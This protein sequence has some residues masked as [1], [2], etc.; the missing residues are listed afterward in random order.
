ML[1]EAYVAK[2]L[3]VSDDDDD[4]GGEKRESNSIVN[5]RKVLEGYVSR[6]EDL[7]KYPTREF[8]DDGISGVS[9]NRPGVQSLLREVRENRVRCIIVKDLSRFGRNYIEV[10][11]YIEQIFP[12]L[13]VRFIAVSDHFDSFKNPV[14][15]EIGFKNLIHD[16]YSRDLSRKIKSVKSLMQ[17]RGAY[18]GGDVP[19]GYMRSGQKDVPYVPDPEAAQVVKRIFNLAAAGN[20]S[21]GIAD[22]LNRDAVPTPGV[23]KNRRTNENYRL[24]NEKSTLW[25]ASQVGV[26]IQNEVY[27]GTSILHKLSTVRPRVSKR[28][29]ESEYLKIENHHEKLVEEELFQKAQ[30]ALRKRKKRGGYR[31][32]EN[33]PALKGKV[34]CGCCGYGMS[35]KRTSKAPYYYCRMGNGCGSHIKIEAA[36]LDAAILDVLRKYAEACY[37]R[38]TARESE[39]VQMLTALSKGKE[40]KRL[41]EIRAEHCKSSRLALY[42]QWKEGKISKEEYVVK[43]EE[44]TKREAG[45]RNELE[46]LNQQLEGMLSVREDFSQESVLAGFANVQNLTKELADELIGRV[47]V[48]EADRVEIKWKV[49]MCME[50]FVGKC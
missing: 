4:L 16:L 7:S 38:E 36:L 26:I 40:E 33:P 50:G 32:D 8:V 31:K 42:R 25:I 9:F 6:H 14:G 5:Q 24:K 30:A 39:R 1:G 17:K 29:D 23:Y 28:N 15:M 48:Y 27:V 2:Y 3:R 35:L 22:I 13:G 49:Q 12:F 46:M 11:D 37:E 47:E 10:G 43:K 19:Y 21:S 18:S 20:T 44:L 34:K 41:L 45:C